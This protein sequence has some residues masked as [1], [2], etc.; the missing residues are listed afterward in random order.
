VA[1][2]TIELDCFEKAQSVL[3][4]GAEFLEPIH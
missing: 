3:R 4:K 1:E 2:G